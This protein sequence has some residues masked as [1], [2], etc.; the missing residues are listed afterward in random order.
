MCAGQSDNT[1]PAG[2]IHLAFPERTDPVRIPGKSVEGHTD[3][4][5]S[6]QVG[7]IFKQNI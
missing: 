2:R 1:L 3:S 6:K 7:D 4:V 5:F